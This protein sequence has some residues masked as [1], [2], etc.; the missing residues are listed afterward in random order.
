MPSENRSVRASWRGWV[1]NALFGAALSFL[2]LFL[3]FSGERLTQPARAWLDG[4]RPEWLS[5]GVVFWIA[6]GLLLIAHFFRQKALDDARV[7][8]QTRLEIAAGKLEILVRTQPPAEFQR[9]LGVHVEKNLVLFDSTQSV[10]EIVDSLSVAVEGLALLAGLY[11]QGTQ[12]NEYAANLMI[13][14]PREAAS[15][16]EWFKKISFHPSEVP[17]VSLQGLMVLDPRFSATARA[18]VPK[19]TSPDPNMPV[20][21]LPVPVDI[22]GTPD[23]S[24]KG[25]W[26]VLPGAP[27]V[28]ACNS[29]EH[30]SPATEI[31]SWCVKHGDL[32]K[33]IRTEIA[34]Y[35][36]G[37]KH[38]NGFCT[39]PLLRLQDKFENDDNRSVIAALNFHWS[40]ANLLSQRDPARAFNE[41]IFPIRALMARQL[42]R[43]EREHGWSPKVPDEL[44]S[45]AS[46][47]IE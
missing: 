26:C 19:A 25:G 29:F 1:A 7:D 16:P 18:G 3:G 8:D 2:V 30:F 23:N 36:N 44:K 15:A 5:A 41:C 43:L 11:D 12:T 20:F 14:V 35:F 37:A 21:C 10:E 24:G 31:E 38:I 45:E 34:D 27:R 33:K 28:F 4:L 13:F 32:T 46:E 9:Q 6:I 17:L 47:A 39:S 40:S 22:G 42:L